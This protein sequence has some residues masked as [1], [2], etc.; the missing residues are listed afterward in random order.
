MHSHV[1][2]GIQSKKKKILSKRGQLS[3]NN[4]RERE[5]FET[6]SKRVQNSTQKKDS[7]TQEKEDIQDHA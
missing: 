4:E 5:Q 3:L 2:S 1:Y 7:G 6:T